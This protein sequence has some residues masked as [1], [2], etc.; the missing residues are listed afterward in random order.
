[1]TQ[2]KYQSSSMNNQQPTTNNQQRA[3][4]PRSKRSFASGFTLIEIM[5]ALSIFIVVMT[6]S[7]G[8]IVGI[9]DTNRKSRSLKVVM[10]NLNIAM[11][12]MSKEIRFGRNYHC[13]ERADA[14]KPSNSPKNCDRGGE[15]LSFLSN[16]GG[17]IVYRIKNNAI[18]ASMD[19]GSTYA[20]ITAPEIV[21]NNL[22]F[23]VL[24]AGTNNTLQPR[25][26]ISVG[27]EAGTTDK[28]KSSFTLQTMISQRY[29]D[30]P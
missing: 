27:G 21:I 20:P 26:H 6:V 16:D 8:S 23:Y 22:K 28:T 7:M 29:L 13:E 5:T 2:A 3:G 14:N 15:L 12:T 9:F 30:N 17:H 4:L 18:E 25:V 1:M 10:S 11:E 24:G 19:G